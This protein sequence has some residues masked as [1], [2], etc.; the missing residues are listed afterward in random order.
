M[1]YP[2]FLALLSM[3]GV[4]SCSDSFVGHQDGGGEPTEGGGRP[5]GGAS[6]SGAGGTGG[7]GGSG[8]SPVTTGPGGDCVAAEDCQVL[9]NTSVTCVQSHCTYECQKDYG[10]CN[11]DL[12]NG[13]ETDLRVTPTHCGACSFSCETECENSACL[14][15]IAVSAGKAHTCALMANGTVR[16]WGDNANGQLGIGSTT[17]AGLPTPVQ[18]LTDASKVRASIAGDFTCAIRA[19]GTLACWGNNSFGQLGIGGPSPAVVLS[20]GKVLPPDGNAQQD[21][22]VDDVSLGDMFACAI[23]KTPSVPHCWGTNN[24]G[25]LGLGPE[26]DDNA[27]VPSLTK[28]SVAATALVSGLGHTCALSSGNVHCWGYNEF[29]QLGVGDVNPREEP[30]LISTSALSNVESLSSGASFVCAKKTNQSHACWGQA[31]HYQIPGDS[32]APRTSPVAVPVSHAATQ[33][34]LGGQH[35]GALDGAQMKGWGYNAYGQLGLGSTTETVLPSTL[36]PGLS[37]ILTASFGANHS[38]AITQD[39]TKRRLWCWGRNDQGQVGTGT[40]TAPITTPT[41]VQWTP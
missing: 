23:P 22:L 27:Y 33:L 7:V 25:R 40:V 14:D 2:A 21:F 26:E 15:P 3:P 16:C 5:H 12:S 9:A 20:P 32:A 29:G 13:C 4:L 18:G 24:S 1:R 11:T 31:T 39:G 38:C 8:G 30:T 10:D 35:V 37:G 36:V 6:G 28:G 17:D 19:S 34:F 41:L